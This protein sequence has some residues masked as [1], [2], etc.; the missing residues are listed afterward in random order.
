MLEIRLI[1]PENK[2]DIKLPNEAFPLFGRLLPS[3][4]EGQWSY[5]TEK[6]ETVGEMCFP[7]E[8]YCYEDMA[9][10]SSFIGAYDGDRCVGLAI[11][12]EDFF[13]YM[14]LYDLKVNRAYR[15]QGVATALL[16]KAKGLAQEKGYRGIHTI[17]QDNN[18]GACLFYLRS[19]FVIGGLD[20][21]CYKGTKQEGKADVLF[22]WDF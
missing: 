19:G 22:Y 6:F 2:D 1:G 8:D 7:D 3:Y 12:Q 14:Y 10:N 21:A 20:T 15:Q 4:R 18:L 5:R 17:G 16:Q 11:M 9:E 13:R